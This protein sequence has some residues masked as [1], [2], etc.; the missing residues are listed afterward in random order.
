MENKLC[1]SCADIQHE[2]ITRTDPTITPEPSYPITHKKGSIRLTDKFTGKARALRPT[3]F[4]DINHHKRMNRAARDGFRRIKMGYDERQD[5][6][7]IDP[8]GNFYSVYRKYKWSEEFAM[9][10]LTDRERENANRTNGHLVS[11]QET[12]KCIKFM[13]SHT[14]KRQ[15]AGRMETK[16]SCSRCKEF[17]TVDKY[18]QVAMSHMDEEDHPVVRL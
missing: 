4:A 16:S 2:E 11:T 8:D 1:R 5:L 12:C 17:Y 13:W 10:K 9:V 14:F 15:K 6:G 7:E 18:G 3:K